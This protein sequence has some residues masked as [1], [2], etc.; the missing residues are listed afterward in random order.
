MA[1][2]RAERDRAVRAALSAGVTQRAAAEAMGVSHQLVGQI[3][4]R[5]E[6]GRP[7]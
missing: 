5:R 1:E 3:A 7:R 4:L 6:P 2:L